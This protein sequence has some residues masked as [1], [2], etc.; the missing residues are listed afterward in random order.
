MLSDVNRLRIETRMGRA[1]WTL[2][3]L[4]HARRLIFAGGQKP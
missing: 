4:K 3:I 1:V 2:P